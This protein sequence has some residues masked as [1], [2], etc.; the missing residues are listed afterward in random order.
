MLKNLV[1]VIVVVAGI[2]ALPV[3]SHAQPASSELK[4]SEEL[5]QQ[6]FDAY[7]KG[8]FAGAIGLYKKA[9]QTYANGVILF[10]IA[11]I[12]DRKLKDKEQALEYYQRYLRSGD[13]EPGLVKRSIERIE[14]VR[15]EIEASKQAQPD[16]G[17]SSKSTPPQP[18]GPSTSADS[19]APPSSPPVPVAEPKRSYRIAGMAAAGAGAAGLVLGG[20]FGFRAKSKND[21]AARICNGSVCPDARGVA[22]TNDARQAAQISTVSFIVGGVL[23]AGGVGLIIWGPKQEKRP[24]QATVRITPQVDQQLGLAISGTW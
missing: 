23:A 5:A 18:S 15:A 24:P 6:A 1:C 16:D 21:D 13:T 3:V 11:N 10:N 4:Q 12:F 8:D 9:Y 17:S 19:T 22:L 7:T 14:I 2:A 20:I